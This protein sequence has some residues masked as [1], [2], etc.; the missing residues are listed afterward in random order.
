MPDGLLIKNTLL[1]FD[2][3]RASEICWMYPTR[4]KHHMN[5]VPV[6]TDHGIAVRLSSGL[7]LKSKCDEA[8]VGNKLNV[9]HKAAP[10]AVLG[11]SK[12][13]DKVWRTDRRNFVVEIDKRYHAAL[14]ARE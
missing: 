6:S 7:I 2:F 14:R 4:T 13:L 5:F 10:W 12:E 3:F 9:L 1:T 11:V 8:Q